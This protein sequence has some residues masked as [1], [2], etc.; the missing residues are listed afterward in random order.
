MKRNSLKK[1]FHPATSTFLPLLAAILFY[2]IFLISNAYSQQPT[3]EWVARIPGP[4]NDLFGPFLEVDKQA[5]NI[6][7]MA[8]SNGRHYMYTQLKHI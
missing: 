5:Q 4:T 2:F 6:I 1:S 8:F 3:Q 7:L